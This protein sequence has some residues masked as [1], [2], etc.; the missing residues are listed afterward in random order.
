MTTSWGEVDRP[1]STSLRN[2]WLL[3]AADV[4]DRVWSWSNL[5]AV[6]PISARSR[7]AAPRSRAASSAFPLLTA[8]NANG[9]LPPGRPGQ[10]APGRWD[11]QNLRR[12]LRQSYLGGEYVWSKSGGPGYRRYWR[13]D[14]QG[15][16]GRGGPP[17]SPISI[18]VPAVLEP[19]LFTAV[20]EALKA[21]ARG[22]SPRFYL[23]TGHLYGECGNRY[24]GIWRKSKGWKQYRCVAEYQGGCE[25]CRTRR[26]HADD[27]EKAVWDEIARVLS[28]PE[29]LIAM[30][31]EFLGV[32]GQQI[33][34]ERE[35]T[36][37]IDAKVAQHE[38]ALADLLTQAAL[39][40][41]L[42]SKPIQT[43]IAL[44]EEQLGAL[45]RHR[46]QLE[47]WQQEA[48]AQSAQKRRL[49]ELADFAAARL[50]S[51]PNEEKAAVLDLLEVRVTLADE[52]PPVKLR[53]EGVVYDEIV[54]AM[55]GDGEGLRRKVGRQ[56]IEP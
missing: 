43:A 48:A 29:R 45:H 33:E 46:S 22:T 52:R 35:Q 13:K 12:A 18:P 7:S 56:G 34:T 3:R 20:Q 31:A 15:V 53:I 17:G 47:G 11:R 32:R 9:L 30:A 21:T 26:V 25:R 41:D 8:T 44:I 10:E 38:R 24:S 37:A 49:W 5:S 6:A 50:R 51:M 14:R 54:S 40:G 23:L 28:E 55:R 27:V 36:Q 19:E 42:S 4:T 16:K 1:S 39:R 2:S